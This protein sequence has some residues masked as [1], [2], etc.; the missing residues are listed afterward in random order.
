MEREIKFKY[1]EAAKEQLEKFKAAQIKI[2][3]D[4]IKERKYFPGEDYIEI[5]ASDIQ[6]ITKYIKYSKPIKYEP[7]YLIIYV[8]FFIGIIMFV[9]GFSYPYFMEILRKYRSPQAMIILAGIAMI[10]LSLL[11]YIFTK[12]IETRRR[13]KE[14]S[15]YD[16]GLKPLDEVKAKKR[17]A[18]D[19]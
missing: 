7:K 1:T 11:L 10:F 17:D 13:I 4:A 2:I 3:E 14:L 12:S 6:E 19:K 9:G 16:F 18:A 15:L 8:Y 5:T